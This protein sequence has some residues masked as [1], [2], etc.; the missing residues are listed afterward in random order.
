MPIHYFTL[1][2]V[3]MVVLGLVILS[4]FGKHSIVESIGIC[5]DE[6]LVLLPSEVNSQHSTSSLN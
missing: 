2:N 1:S 5:K 3:G 6:V 4:V